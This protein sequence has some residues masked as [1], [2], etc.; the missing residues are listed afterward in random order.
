MMQ[1]LFLLEPVVI[2]KE[3]A[4]EAIELFL[5]TEFEDEERHER[6]IK[7]IDK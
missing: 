3:H 4:L 2:S 1:M 5:S 6:R 7:K